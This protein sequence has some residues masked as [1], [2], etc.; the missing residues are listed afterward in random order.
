MSLQPLFDK[1]VI[2]RDDPETMSKGGIALPD[3]AKGRPTSGKVLAV[4]TGRLLSSGGIGPMLVTV[5]DKVW[6]SN[7][8]GSEFE[9]GGTR[10]CV[11]SQDDILAVERP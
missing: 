6:F 7:Y 5:G 8:A 10:F 4:G 9:V 3:T 2:K 1:V 11:M